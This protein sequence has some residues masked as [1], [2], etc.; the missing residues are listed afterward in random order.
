M[1]YLN[2]KRQT[3]NLVHHRTVA[4]HCRRI[5][6]VENHDD[7]RDRF[8]NI[9]NHNMI[10]YVA[11]NCNNP[12]LDIQILLINFNQIKSS[13]MKLKKTRNIFLFLYV[14]IIN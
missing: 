5:D 10:A 9:G 8:H 11:Y 12:F 13:Q 4:Y 1:K 2:K 3:P 6:D 7:K 14:Y